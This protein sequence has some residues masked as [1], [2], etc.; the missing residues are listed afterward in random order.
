[1]PAQERLRFHLER[2]IQRGALHQLLLM[3]A[4][5]ACISVVGGVLAWIVDPAAFDPAGAVWW[6]FLRLTDPGYLG[7]DEGALLR[8][9]ST[10]LTVLGYVIFLAR[11]SRS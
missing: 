11:S 8:T 2:W 7:D 10:L 3:A 1:M 9:V 4:V 6:A 5:I